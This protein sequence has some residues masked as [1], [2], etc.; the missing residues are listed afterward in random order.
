MI[1]FL[2]NSGGSPHTKRREVELTGTNCTPL[3]GEEGSGRKGRREGGQ[4]GRG[5][6]TGGFYLQAV[7]AHVLTVTQGC[8]HKGSRET[9]NATGVVSKLFQSIHTEVSISNPNFIVVAAHAWLLH[10]AAGGLHVH[11]HVHARGIRLPKDCDAC[12]RCRGRCDDNTWK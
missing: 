5:V 9:S 8:C 10:L 1:P 11:V 6:N 2:P 3:G 4:D 7:T 12:G